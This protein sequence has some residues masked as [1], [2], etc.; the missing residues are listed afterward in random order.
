MKE[1][2]EFVERLI[3]V[4]FGIWPKG[5]ESITYA[6]SE[7]PITKDEFDKIADDIFIASGYVRVRQ[8]EIMKA[9]DWAIHYRYKKY[10]ADGNVFELYECGKLRK[11]SGEKYFRGP[12][13]TWLC[14]KNYFGDVV[15]GD[16]KVFT[17]HSHFGC[18]GVLYK[19]QN[20]NFYTGTEL[21]KAHPTVLSCDALGQICRGFDKVLFGKP[22]DVVEGWDLGDNN[23]P[24]TKE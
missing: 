5:L 4:N 19:D 20:G 12:R 3:K 10:D 22:R 1:R 24:S 17:D 9:G 6:D 14:F 23:T 16:T 8:G 13:E 11:H 21:Q 7:P 15:K 18:E 2:Q